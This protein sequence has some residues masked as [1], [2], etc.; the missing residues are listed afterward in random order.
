[1][2]PVDKKITPAVLLAALGIVYGDIGTSP[3]YAFKES[4]GGSHGAGV[5]VDAI[6]GVL[7]MIFW[8]ITLVVSIKYVLFVLRAHNEGEGGILALLALLLRQVPAAGRLHDFAIVAGLIGAAMFYGDSVI[9]PAISVLSAIEGLQ[10][11]SPR[12]SEWIIPLTLLV[13]IVLFAAQKRGTAS[14]GRAFGPIMVV[15]FAV[16]GTLGLVQIVQ[17]PQVL[18]AIDP[19][20]ALRFAAANPGLT[21]VVLGAVFLA[22][23]GGE[24]LYAD[25]G[26]FGARPI[27]LAWYWLVMP[28][29]LLNYFGQGALVIANPAAAESPFFLM[30]PPWLRLP[31]VFLATA[32]TVIASQAVI[33]GAFS[34]TSQAVK[35]GYLPR[36]P[37]E[38]T[39]S[40]EAGQIYV[41]LVNLLLLVAVVFLVMGF[42]NSSDLAAAYGIAVA[43]TMVVTTLG[44]MVVARLR[45]D[46]AP[47]QVLLVFLPLLALDLVFLAAN[48]MKIPNG[49]WF[50]LAFAAFLYL[51][52]ATWKR[53]RFLLSRQQAKNGI[54][55]APFLKSLSI[56]PPQRVEGTA[57]F[58]TQ[59]PGLVPSSLLH[60]LKHNRVL[61]ERVI[62]LTAISRN[63]PHV[64]PADMAEIDELGDGCFAIKVRLGFQDPYDVAYIAGA[65]SKH[66]E[67]ELSLQE[68]S[69]FL[70]RQTVMIA[71]DGSMATWRQRMFGWM[72]RNAQPAS[73][74]FHMPPNRVIEIGTQVVV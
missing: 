60:N 43:T 49:G 44:V 4:L 26:H 15:W 55:L 56:Y 63:V 7:S 54:E 29:L 71:R 58:M 12:F 68:T 62:F 6:Y 37:I 11:V 2:T 27:R 42:G 34:I 59:E 51:V 8:S 64:D 31:L 67:F 14:V 46:W 72:L 24:A 39:S 70:S 16:I 66:N 5:G 35:L 33:S 10:V 61:H 38:Y 40:T 20:H 18:E 73:D 65:L 32:A 19:L 53:G 23:T 41:P 21:F 52:F 13:L 45:W 48:S 69:F 28:C 47:W 3:L 9:T 36:M 17:A 22:V 57:V 1:M 25:M 50:P 74:F 30:A